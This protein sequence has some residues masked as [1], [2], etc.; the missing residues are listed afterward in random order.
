MKL[1]LDLSGRGSPLRRAVTPHPL[2]IGKMR[3]SKG[4]SRVPLLCMHRWLCSR[5]RC[6]GSL[7]LELLDRGPRRP[8][9]CV[10]LV[11][12]RHNAGRG[13]NIHPACVSATSKLSACA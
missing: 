3:A 7:R 12:L 1:I 5:L 11:E 8:P 9:P 6:G 13:V 4:C 10:L 2:L